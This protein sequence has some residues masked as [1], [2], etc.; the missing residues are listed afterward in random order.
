MN[1]FIKFFI[2]IAI[3]FPS[4]AQYSSANQNSQDNDI[5]NNFQ[6]GYVNDYGT[7]KTFVRPNSKSTS[8]YENNFNFFDEKQREIERIIPRR[9]KDPNTRDNKRNSIPLD[10]KP[11][12]I[13]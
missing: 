8:G 12:P 1:R 11:A 6:S 2:F 10:K 5:S 3:T 13:I 9:S 4:K 7:K